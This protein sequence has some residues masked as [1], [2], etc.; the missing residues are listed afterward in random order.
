MT[1]PSGPL[2][3]F[4]VTTNDWVLF[5]PSRARRPHDYLREVSPVEAVGPCPFC[6]GNEQGSEEVVRTPGADGV[7]W[8]VR[9][10]RNKYP[11]LD[12]ALAPGL[13]ELGRVFREMVGFGVHEVVIESPEHSRALA[14]QPVE[15]IE[16]VLAVLQ[17]R[18]TS[19]M[20]ERRLRSIVVFR[21]QGQRAGTSL[22]HPHWQIIATPV[23]PRLLRLK[24]EVATEYFDHT[25]TCLYVVALEEELASGARILAENDAFVAVLPFASHVP[26]QV[27]ILPRAPAG[28]FDGLEPDLR[29][30]LAALL[31]E[32]L[33]RLARALHGPDFNLTVNTAP[34][35]DEDEPYFVWHIDVLPRLTTPAGF[36][37]GSGMAINPVLPED[38]AAT[39]R[40]T[41]FP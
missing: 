14:D 12:P 1:A 16:R 40:A 5:A 19:L 13:R 2:L 24:H 4:D 20:Q 41:T 8:Q 30:S 7:A 27:R 29:R 34:L 26:Y 28:S 25:G 31:K 35:G 15:Q 3:R 33:T 10:I 39:L 11:A 9:V 17:A 37:L 32:V 22:A 21:N 23:V 38:A 6:P 18:Y 36:E